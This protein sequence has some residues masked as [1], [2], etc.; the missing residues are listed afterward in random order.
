MRGFQGRQDRRIRRF[1]IREFEQPARCLQI[2]R[3][4]AKGRLVPGAYVHRASLER[5]AVHEADNH[6]RVIRLAPDL[7]ESARGHGAGKGIAGMRGNKDSGFVGPLRRWNLFEKLADNREEL[8]RVLRVE[9]ARNVGLSEI[10]GR[11]RMP[12][13][14]SQR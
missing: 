5:L 13:Q 1:G 4:D 7:A 9:T 3:D 8:L 14:E 2:D 10:G 11:R 6:D 12:E